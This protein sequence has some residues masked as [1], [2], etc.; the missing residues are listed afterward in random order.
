MDNRRYSTGSARYEL[1][2]LERLKRKTTR[3]YDRALNEATD[4]KQRTEAQ[5]LSRK[6]DHLNEKIAQLVSD[7]LIA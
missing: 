7:Y 2:R 6:E 3:S 1:A 4:K 5:A